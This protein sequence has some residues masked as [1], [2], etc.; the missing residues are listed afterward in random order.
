[1][2]LHKRCAVIGYGSWA[3]TLVAQLTANGKNVNWLITNKEVEN[4]ILQ[5]G[6]N[7]KYEVDLKLN[8]SRISIYS[9]INKAIDGCNVIILACP[10]AYLHTYLQPLTESIKD[11]TVISAIKGIVPQDLTTVLEF[12][13][14]IYNV[15][16]K[17]LGLISGPTHA[18]EVSRGRLS[19]LTAASDSDSTIR[20]IENL[21]SSD[22]LILNRSHDIFGI[23]YAAVLKNIYAIAV[24]LALGT[25]YGENFISVLVSGC[26][27]E[28][29]RF[30]ET[31]FPYKRDIFSAAYMGD[32]IVTCYSDYS[33]NRRLGLLIGRGNTVK[34]AMN[35]MT[36]IAEGYYS[37]ECIHKV[38]QA[39]GISMPIVETVYNVL[40]RGENPRKA[41]ASL[42]K[43]L[44]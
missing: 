7:P 27:G 34:S 40:Y 22:S 21:F 41:I 2:Y 17:S 28:M 24:G 44:G 32:L 3:T 13:Q 5:D 18:E 36:M 10:S 23:E 26:A 9:D 11:Y 6:H 14:A 19:F 15:P 25:G 4:G 43:Q 1:M 37:A 35:E 20:I 30:L 31:R 12:L 29:A 39:H 16:Y 8:R 42:A 33:R 38:N